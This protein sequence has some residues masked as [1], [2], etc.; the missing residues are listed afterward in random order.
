MIFLRLNEKYG[1]D[2]TDSISR[3][4]EGKSVEEVVEYSKV[5]PQLVR[6]FQP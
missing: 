6:P 3:E 1:R 5:L 4:V 2:D